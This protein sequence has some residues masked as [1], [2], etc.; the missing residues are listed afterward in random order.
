MCEAVCSRFV[1]SDEDVRKS[2]IE[3]LRDGLLPAF[4]D[5]N[6][7]SPFVDSIILRCGAALT[8]VDARVRED[9][10]KALKAVID[11]APRIVVT[12]RA[13]RETLSRFNAALLD[14]EGQRK[15]REVGTSIQRDVE[16]KITS[17]QCCTA[18]LMAL[19]REMKLQARRRAHP[20]L[21]FE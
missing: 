6:G 14:S 15:D 1:D 12:R 10:P 3:C 2:A 9:A 18:F 11:F 17:L 4:Q 13:P 19:E 16:G 21:P 20:P 5:E 8:H 7:A